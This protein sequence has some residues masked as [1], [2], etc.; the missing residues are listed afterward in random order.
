MHKVVKQLFISGALLALSFGNAFAEEVMKPFVLGYTTSG[1]MAAV[2]TEVKGK[3]ESAGF[4]IAGTYSPYDGAVVIAI[5]ND[6]LKKAA[7]S[8]E[9]GGYAAGQRVSLTQVGD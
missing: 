7:A 3:V 1:D 9:F 8:S 2:T 5:T 4:E 6:D